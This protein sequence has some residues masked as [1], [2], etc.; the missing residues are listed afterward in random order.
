MAVLEMFARK[1]DWHTIEYG[2]KVK[3]LELWEIEP[4][5]APVLARRFPRAVVATCDSYQRLGSAPRKFDVVI[6]DNPISIHDGHF[7]HF[8]IFPA[9]FQWL[10]DRSFLIVDIIPCVDETA[11]REF[12]QAFGDDHML[13]RKAFYGRECADRIPVEMM[14]AQYNAL[15]MAAGWTVLATALEPRNEVMSYLL[16]VLERAVDGAVG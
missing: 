15:C 14:L 5:F 16:L 7:E 13:A 9:V 1:G 11:R 12:P 6:S 3:Y 10:A 4:A 8:D 2:S